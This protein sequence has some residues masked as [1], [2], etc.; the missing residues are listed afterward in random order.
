M[1]INLFHGLVALGIIVL[2]SVSG[3][4][5]A[6]RFLRVS[7]DIALIGLAPTLGL[8]LYLVLANALG[9]IVGTPA[10]FVWAALGVILLG[11]G[12]L[13]C[14]TSSF[15]LE[16][17]PRHVHIFLW[18]LA[19]FI[20]IVHMRILTS[21]P[22]MISTLPLASTI[23]SGNFPIHEVQNPWGLLAYH[24]GS[25][26]L[27]A[28]FS[29]LANISVATSF[30]LQSLWGAIGAVFLP[31]ALLYRVTRSWTV[32]LWGVFIGVLGTGFEWYHIFP[33]MRDLF[34]HYVLGVPTDV[35]FQE[36]SRTFA[37]T[38]GHSL[39][40]AFN[41]RW[42]TVGFGMLFAIF[43]ACHEAFTAMQMRD[44]CAWSAVAVFCSLAMA[45]VMETSL[46]LLLPVSL[47]FV[48]FV[49]LVPSTGINWVRT[50]V[51]SVVIL[52]LSFGIALVQ[53]GILTHMLYPAEVGVQSFGIVIDGTMGFMSS[54]ELRMPFWDPWF[55]RS[56]GLP[57]LLFPFALWYLW[58]KRK[59][60]PFLVFVAAFAGANI[61]LPFVIT[62]L[63]RENEFVRILKLGLICSSFLIGCAMGDVWQRTRSVGVRWLL[64]AVALLMT[65]S[66]LLYLPTRLIIPTLRFEYA[67]LLAPMPPITESQMQMYEWVKNNSQLKDYFYL[68]TLVKEP[69]DEMEGQQRDRILFMGYTGRYTVGWYGWG[70]MSKERIAAGVSIEQ[71]CQQDAFQLLNVRYLVVE[72]A[73]RAEWFQAHCKADEWIVRYE[74]S[75]NAMPYPRVY[76][77]ALWRSSSSPRL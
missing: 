36:L 64:I 34:Q 56:T 21:D 50:F 29:W 9:Y 4:N 18:V 31:A 46:V 47:F 77:S 28:A 70:D 61:L 60:W 51:I 19:A 25:A 12:S 74:E 7:N 69:V 14:R 48:A 38:F 67:P 43:Y 53:G 58:T 3:W 41:L 17:A 49:A 76:E 10:A 33:L 72:S 54:G 63:P 30:D 66:S 26:Y 44:R 39:A 22:W 15:P 6:R 20:G 23:A 73:E 13:W 62:F 65:L 11:A 68:R 1:I 5:M 71:T 24:Y 37:S 52:G 40:I 45:L 59:D 57:F 42:F 8:S 35:P 55:I 27:A 2:F 32:T 75:G 16:H